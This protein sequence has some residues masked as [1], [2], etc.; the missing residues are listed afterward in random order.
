MK[1]AGYLIVSLAFLACAYLS[2]L[3]EKI[4]LWQP[5]AMLMGI[6]AIGLL[7]VFRGHKNVAKSEQTKTT[8]LL[9][10]I[11]SLK[12]IVEKITDLSAGKEAIQD[13]YHVRH[14]IDALFM[15]LINDFVEARDSITHTYGIKSYTEVMSHFA[16]GER[17]LNR[18]W[19][20]SADGYI[21]ELKI[22]IDKAKDQF[23]LAQE[24]MQK[25]SNA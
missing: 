19:S 10:V 11:N 8:N 3:D 5:F 16:G 18:V 23:V 4:V 1:K 14:K 2:S 6:G 22:Y 17:Y 9:I 12:S 15:E 13:P 24:C 25:F 7:L 21:D 20:A